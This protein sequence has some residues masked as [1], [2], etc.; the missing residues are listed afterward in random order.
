MTKPVTES[1]EKEEAQIKP[2]DESDLKLLMRYGKGP[3]DDKLKGLE[4]KITELN[5]KLSV[6]NKEQDTGLAL[7]S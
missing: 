5:K 1:D 4:E 3:Y 2:L 6:V 7:P